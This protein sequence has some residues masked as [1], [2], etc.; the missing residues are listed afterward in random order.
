MALVR[1]ARLRAETRRDDRQQHRLRAAAL[2][3]PQ[4]DRIVDHPT[5]EV[6]PRHYALSSVPIRIR[7]RYSGSRV[8][9][10]N[11]SARNQS[12]VEESARQGR[13]FV[14][15]RLLAL[16]PTRRVEGQ[17][18]R[19]CRKMPGFSRGG[20][21]LSAFFKFSIKLSKPCV[22]AP[23]SKISPAAAERLSAG[24]RRGRSA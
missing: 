17:S 22:G 21:S 12:G 2:A 4:T 1:V 10:S 19:K 8:L 20:S 16:S 18:F 6:K 14:T 24:P 3:F 15:A 7:S 9:G 11:V 13:T 5:S 23:S